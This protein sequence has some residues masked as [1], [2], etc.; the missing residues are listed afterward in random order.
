TRGGQALPGFPLRRDGRGSRG[1][2]WDPAGPRQRGK[3]VLRVRTLRGFDRPLPSSPSRGHRWGAACGSRPIGGLRVG[4]RQRR[5][6]TPRP[7]RRARP[8]P[9]P[10]TGTTRERLVYAARKLLEDGGYGAASVQAIAERTGVSTGALYRHFPSKAE[11]FV[12]VF[13]D[14]AR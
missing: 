10:P 1:G 14:A 13:R 5:P 7:I 8:T 6:I 2:P 9:E 4:R 11:L 3:R 12:E